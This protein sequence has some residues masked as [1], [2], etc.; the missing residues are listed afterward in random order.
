M[1]KYEAP[2]KQC[3]LH[4][5]EQLPEQLPDEQD[6]TNIPDDQVFEQERT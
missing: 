1:Q 6:D 2:T 5:S 3:G 4:S